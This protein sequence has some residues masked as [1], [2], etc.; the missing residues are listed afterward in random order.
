MAGET[1]DLRVSVV[2]PTRN[3]PAHAFACLQSIL[4]GNGFVDLVVVD[5]SDDSATEGALRAIDDPRVRFVRTDTR[6]VS[7]G[8]NLGIALTE[9]EIIAFT[10]DD[11]RAKVD[12]IRRIKNVFRAHPDV[13]VVCGRVAVPEEIRSA[14]WAEAFRPRTREWQGRYPPF[15]EWGITANLSVRRSILAR[16]GVFDPFL[17]AGAPL[18]SGGEPDFLFRVLRAGCKVVNAEEVMVEHVGIRQFGVETRDLIVRYG[19]GTGAA[20]FKH[21]RLGDPAGFRVYL[22]FLNSSVLRVLRN[23][24]SGRRPIGAAF[25]RGFLSGTVASWHFRIDR[26]RREYVE[27]RSAHRA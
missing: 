23:I 19:R 18:L 3:R 22:R 12:W 14:G 15:G 13:G 27:R 2:V 25:L 6:G 7:N 9:S 8:R 5:Q 21:V 1:S 24:V 10:D 26:R 16:V 20:L 17:G 11:C 4:A